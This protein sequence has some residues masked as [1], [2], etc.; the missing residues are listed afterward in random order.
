MFAEHIPLSLMMIDGDAVIQEC[1]YHLEA[2]LGKRRSEVVGTALKDHV[3]AGSDLFQLIRDAMDHGIVMKAYDHDIH[4]AQGPTIRAHL[5]LSPV[6]DNDTY[7]H[8]WVAIDPIKGFDRIERQLAQN[9]MTRRAGL[10]A[11]MLAHE[12][13]NPL[14]GIRG[15]SQLLMGELEA[16]SNDES[17]RLAQLII[18]EVD[19]ISTTLGKVEFLTEPPDQQQEAV[20][21]HEIL[22]YV[23]SVLDPSL[24]QRVTFVESFDPSIPEVMG[25]RDSLIQLFL[26]LVKN[27]AEA[28]QDTPEATITLGT[29]YRHDF[30]LRIKGQTRLPI[31]ITI[32]DNGPGIP[33]E[34]QDTLFDPFVSTKQDGHGLGLAIAAKIAS[35][36]KG[37]LELAES[38][39]GNTR[40]SVMLPA[41]ASA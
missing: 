9:N 33:E 28:L 22:H 5:Y 11:A 23:Q 4:L 19:R 8:V 24:A 38:H 7:E 18:N 16:D 3:S 13:K 10:M 6:W 35:D 1:N 32:S 25:S 26:N 27:A 29:A 30:H 15:A 12:V 14:A 17:L 37:L 36:H 2:L 41:S 34:L 20:N 31:H 21:I 39:P 40:F